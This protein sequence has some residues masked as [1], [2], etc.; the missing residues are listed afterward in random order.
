MAVGKPRQRDRAVG[1]H[2]QKGHRPAQ[3]DVGRLRGGRHHMGLD[4]RAA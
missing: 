4:R 3:R 1:A 2:L